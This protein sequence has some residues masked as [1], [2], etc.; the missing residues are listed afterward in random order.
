MNYVD[1][2]FTLEEL[3]QAVNENFQLKPTTKA[4]TDSPEIQ[5]GSAWPVI[6]I[7]LALLG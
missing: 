2:S 7:L 1:N 4:I 6:L 3:Q 5:K